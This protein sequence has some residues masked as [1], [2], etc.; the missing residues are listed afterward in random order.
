MFNVIIMLKVLV[1]QS[2]L[3]LCT[4]MECSPPGSFVHG[5]LQA[6]ILE[7]AA[8]FFF[9]GIFPTKGLNLGLLHCRQTLP[10]E[11]PGSP[12]IRLYDLKYR[13]QTHHHHTHT[14]HKEKNKQPRMVNQIV[15]LPLPG[16]TRVWTL[17]WKGN[18]SRSHLWCWGALHDLF[19]GF[20]D[21]STSIISTYFSL[22]H[23]APCHPS[24][25]QILSQSV[26]LPRLSFPPETFF[27]RSPGT[28]FI[29]PQI[30][31]LVSPSLVT[32]S[33]DPSHDLSIYILPG[34]TICD[35]DNC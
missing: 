20:W 35:H 27:P 15:S 18:N 17:S 29:S 32:P 1:T 12:I 2:C 4:R 28:Y 5:I 24:L 21:Q 11:P 30:P 14:N 31:A 34:I 33:K 6:R 23:A 22:G 10:S 9:Q 8:I 3:T 16:L 25:T 19:L 13:K 7:G 26:P